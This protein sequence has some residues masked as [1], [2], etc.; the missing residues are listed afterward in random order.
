M[1][2]DKDIDD[3]IAAQDDMIDDEYGDAV[4]EDEEFADEDWDSYDEEGGEGEEGDAGEGRQKK[5]MP[6]FNKIVI[7]G[8][9]GLGLC[10]VAFTLLTSK[11][12]APPAGGQPRPA[13]Q[14]QQAQQTGDVQRQ[15]L[16]SASLS[17]SA[18]TTQR[19]VIY[20]RNREENVIA[21]VNDNTNDEGGLLNDPSQVRKIEQYRA[22]MEEDLEVQEEQLAA[23]E[24]SVAV[25]VPLAC[26][27]TVVLKASEVC[28][29]THRLIGTVLKEA[30]MGDGVV[31]VI[32]H[33]AKDAGTIADL[34]VAPLE[35]VEAIVPAYLWRFRPYGQFQTRQNPA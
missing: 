27:N 25:A 30:G 1:S 3:E 15:R 24:P 35:S 22:Q 16:N 23:E 28:P 21:P 32:T 11:P 5:P 14:Q 13:Q 12:P 2:G 17:D 4:G 6:K 10:V 20:G 29:A 7:A 34:G 18:P 8:A 31:N 19:D 9:L 26:G 33:D